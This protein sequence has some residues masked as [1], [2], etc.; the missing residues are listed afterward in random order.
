MANI[1][2]DAMLNHTEYGN[3]FWLPWW[4]QFLF[5]T[6]FIILILVAA[7]GNLVVIWIVLA[8]KRM[9]TVTNYFLVNLAVADALISILNTLFTSTFLMYQ[10]W[11]YGNIW[12]KFTMFISICTVVAS[13]LTLMAIAIDRYMAIIHPLRPRP[14]RRVVL[15]I[16]CIWTVSIALAL[17]NLMYGTLITYP[18][19]TQ[20]TCGPVWSDG[21][22]AESKIDF[23][24]NVVII[25]VSYVIPMAILILAYS[26]I[27]KELWGHRAI[28]ENTQLQYDRI[29]S[30]R[31]V[32]KMM[33]FVVIVFGV[34][35]LP[36]HLY[37]LLASSVPDITLAENVQQIY[38]VIYWIAMSNSMYNPIIYCWMN[39][40]FRSGFIEAFC[41]CP[42]RPCKRIKK[43]YVTCLNPVRSFA[44]S[45]K[46]RNGSMMQTMTEYVDE[47]ANAGTGLVRDKRHNS[48]DYDEC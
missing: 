20:K 29:Q 10:D 44:M 42:C 12:C 16:L 3:M 22:P 36:Y 46:F 15:A 26:R 8:H 13:V 43:K 39:E 19:I 25:I 40:R 37:F 24:Y 47:S 38:L 30:K 23:W 11:W 17:P 9:R 2:N 1:T 28:G 7:V 32:V 21:T 6:A 33:I 14:T 4:Q 27:G 35:W 34:C 18:N 41:F 5:I 45:E 31:R 48:N